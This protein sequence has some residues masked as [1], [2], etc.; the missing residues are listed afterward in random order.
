MTIYRRTGF[1]L[2]GIAGIR[3][4]RHFNSSALDPRLGR[5]E[6]L[7][8]AFTNARVHKSTEREAVAGARRA[9]HDGLSHRAR[10]V[11][12]KAAGLVRRPYA[13]MIIYEIASAAVF[14]R[15]VILEE[16]SCR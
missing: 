1:I 5:H 12:I 4:E 3:V 9:P 2:A 13:K 8:S 10:G 15:G 14:R 11:Q 16:E 6:H 7:S